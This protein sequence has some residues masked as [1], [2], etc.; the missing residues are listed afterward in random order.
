[1]TDDLDRDKFDTRISSRK[2]SKE[3]LLYEKVLAAAV[4]ADRRGFFVEPQT[5]M[6]QDET[7]TR[8]QLDIVWGSTKLQ[9]S[10]TDRG[11]RTTSDPNLSLRQETFLQAYLNPLNLKPP[12]TI[13]KQLKITVTELDGW[14]RDK[15]FG[16]AMSAKSEE[17]LK[18]YIPLADQAL[19]QLVQQGDMKAITFINQLT[20]RFDPNA[21]QSLDVPA[22][23]MQIQDIVLR[24]VR[25]PIVKR[26]IARELIALAQGH[27][28]LTSI[29][30]PNGDTIDLETVIEIQPKEG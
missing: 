11:I 18:K 19:G 20:G 26:N 14:M 4:A 27:S 25:D 29:P 23:M 3:Q 22:L 28:P 13:A 8:D 10:L 12:Q 6:D 21:R 24:N 2:A 7:L 5:V 16:A 17:N 15:H 30:E 1:M 9:K